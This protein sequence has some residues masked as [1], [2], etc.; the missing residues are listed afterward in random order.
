M[1]RYVTVGNLTIDEILL[2]GGHFEETQCGG[3][4]LYSAV[5]AHIWSDSVGI[6]S[7][8]G[9]DFPFE[10]LDV[11]GKAGIDI[12]GIS[13][14]EDLVS[15]RA[16]LAYAPDG[17]RS[18]LENETIG[19]GEY[20]KRADE[21]EEWLLYS[22]FAAHFPEAY[23]TAIAIHFAPMPVQA[24]S[25]LAQALW[26]PGRLLTLD[27]PW[28]DG[29]A[30]DYTPQLPLLHRLDALVPS[31]AEVRVFFRGEVDSVTGIRAL[32]RMGPKAT[33]IKLGAD[34]CLVYTRLT[35]RVTHVP[36]FPTVTVDPT[37]AGD[38]F[39]GGLL[40]GLAETGDAVEAARYGTVSASF[41]VEGFSSLYALGITRTEAEK[42]LKSIQTRRI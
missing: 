6:V 24:H 38:A 40:V 7:L 22:P 12:S 3:N 16:G 35:D 2:P 11:V 42:R 39:C 41:I 26:N 13:P 28:W 10:W 32:G 37:G 25:S 9:I 5:G 31:L 1:V 23:E 27:S 33:V 36:A 4:C 34:G 19:R 30:G 29:A 17:E 20:D 18:I 14:L 15:M 21:W 8:V